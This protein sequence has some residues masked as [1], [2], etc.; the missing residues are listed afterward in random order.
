METLSNTVFCSVSKRYG[1]RDLTILS[2]VLPFS[3]KT[4]L[5]GDFPILSDFALKMVFLKRGW[6]VRTVYSKVNRFKFYTESLLNFSKAISYFDLDSKKVVEVMELFESLDKA[7]REQLFQG[8]KC[9][10]SERIID[11]YRKHNVRASLASVKPKDKYMVYVSEKIY[12]LKEKREGA[13]N[14]IRLLA[15]SLK[16]YNIHWISLPKEVI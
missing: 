6:D 13:I 14:Q 11:A 2:E 5:M 8:Q 3:G 16:R 4:I 9:P 15:E 10:E 1:L 12:L 7:E